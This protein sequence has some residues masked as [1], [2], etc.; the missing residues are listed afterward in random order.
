MHKM[1][2]YNV[3]YA[4]RIN[5]ILTSAY[6]CN[7]CLNDGLIFTKIPRVPRKGQFLLW[8]GRCVS[9]SAYSPFVY[10]FISPLSNLFVLLAVD[11]IGENYGYHCRYSFSKINSIFIR[12]SSN[13][14]IVMDFL[15]IIK[16]KLIKAQT[17]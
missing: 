1:H 15:V 8:V 5:P 3:P 9:N 11:G 13:T 17:S 10:T 4:K 12:I 6:S 2:N 7:Y 14:Y 16:C